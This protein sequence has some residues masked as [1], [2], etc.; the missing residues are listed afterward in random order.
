VARAELGPW[1]GPPQPFEV[2]LSPAAGRALYFTVPGRAQAGMPRVRVRVDR[3]QELRGVEEKIKEMGMETF[4][5]ADL[6]DQIRVNALLISIATTLIAGIA[7]VVAAL[8]I[9]NTM[10]MS[11]LERTFEIGIMKATGARDGE[12][13]GLFLM[14]GTLLGAVG[15]VVGL[16]GAWLVSFPGDRFAHYLIAAQTPMQLEGSVFVFRGWIILGIPL[17][18]CLLTTLAAIY[19]ARRAA[20]IDPIE[21]LRQRG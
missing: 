10:L 15:S 17:A 20:R 12:V 14:E 8:G 2:I 6:L 19:P 4:S 1:D 5:L 18:V 21:A 13:M 3:E 11:V 7:L 9:T 16:I